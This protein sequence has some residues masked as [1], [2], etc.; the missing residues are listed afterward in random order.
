MKLISAI[1]CATAT[2]G[3]CLA[4]P[5]VASA[6]TVQCAADNGADVMI[7]DGDHGC[8]ARS[9]ATGKARSAGVDGIG[10]AIASSGATAVGIGAAGGLGASEGVGGV[11]IAVGLGPDAVALTSLLPV[12]GAPSSDT[13][14]VSLALDGSRAQV[15]SG[16]N[17]VV[18]LGVAAFA[19]NAGTGEACLATPVGRWQRS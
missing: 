1:A 18:C 11:P 15:L 10:Y 16:E 2:A 4:A 7:L 13:V 6:N 9:S 8:R 3:A 17:A 14:A 19:W 12:G 5:A